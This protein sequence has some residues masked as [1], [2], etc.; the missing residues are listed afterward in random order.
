[1]HLLFDLD[2]AEKH[3][4]IAGVGGLADDLERAGQREM[5]E[6]IKISSLF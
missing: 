1:M 5:F 4:A 2:F 6:F 3:F